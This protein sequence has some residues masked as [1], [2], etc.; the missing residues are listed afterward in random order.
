MVRFVLVI[1]FVCLP[2]SISSAQC[3]TDWNGD[4][5]TTI[6]EVVRA[7]RD[8][9]HGCSNEAGAAIQVSATTDRHRY[10]VGETAWLEMRLAS[11]EP[12]RWSSDYLATE[13]VKT[14]ILNVRITNGH[15]SRERLLYERGQDMDDVSYRPC[16][17][18][19][20]F[21]KRTVTVPPVLEIA[22]EVPLVEK[23]LDVDE[24]P[25]GPGIYYIDGRLR[26]SLMPEG[27]NAFPH[28]PHL[29]AGVQIEIYE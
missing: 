8:A 26:L 27:R 15:F 20:G 9:L 28:A 29:K 25:L 21:R 12:T 10:R 22:A 1:L 19:T 17:I 24:A 23:L 14:C 4:G 2:A 5:T 18:D 13:P 6:D 16:R 11:E 3:V 7:V